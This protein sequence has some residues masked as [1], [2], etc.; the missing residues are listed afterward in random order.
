MKLRI[1]KV[2]NIS[3]TGVNT[4]YLLIINDINILSLKCH[5]GDRAVIGG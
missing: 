5:K 1:T 3:G 4:Y 2:N